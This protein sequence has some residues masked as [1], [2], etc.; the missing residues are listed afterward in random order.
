MATDVVMPQMG[1]S[2]T[3]GTIV[4]WMKKVGDRIDRDEPLLEITTDK[5]DA[6]VASPAAGIV[7]EIRAQ[8]GD[9]V[10][11]NDVVAVIGAPDAIVTPA[12][13]AGVRPATAAAAAAPAL[14]EP[15]ADATSPAAV[16][17]EELARDRSSPLVRRMAKEHHIDLSQVH[18]T[19]ISGRVTKDD[20]LDYLE[21]EGRAGQAVR[22]RQ[23]KPGGHARPGDRVEPM[24]VLRKKIAE[25]M[26]VSRRT[27][28]H[29]HTV[30]EINFS[31]IARL[32]EIKRAEYAG[33]GN[34]LTYLAFIVKAVA[35]ALR[36]V[37][38]LN[39]SVDGDSIVYHKD[40][41]IGV[42]VALEGGLIV[43]VIRHADD[44]DLPSISR[45]IAD[46][47]TRARAK[48][49]TPE[50]VAGGTFT[51]TNPGMLG[52]Q[53]GTP[54]INQ[55]QV[56][57]LAVGAIEKRPAVVNDAVTVQTMGYLALGFDHRVIDG[58]VA[59]GFM[60]QV[61]HALEDWN[62]NEA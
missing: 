7:I 49:L 39:S 38:V 37:P 48:Q 15:A 60:A 45:S 47:A 9:T 42:A 22:D 24:S 46:L 6:E 61:K 43:P 36:A 59:D 14:P 11:V 33:R 31:P 5:V 12:A 30:F 19:G 13:E 25:H 57:I 27:S 35:G 26:V 29:V 40:I 2:I 54:I 28:A 10:A 23:P 44:H 18:G 21:Q 51:V 1:E 8:E 3:E 17:L 58:A 41:N 16:S 56:A 32:R 20:L 50:E 62:P 55:P 4:R 34:K 53:F 52:A